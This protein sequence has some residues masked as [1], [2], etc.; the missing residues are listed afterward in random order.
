MATIAYANF[1]HQAVAP[2]VQ[3]GQNEWL[4]ELFHGPTFAFKD[5][6]MQL[7]AQL[8]NN[9]L[10][11]K[12]TKALVLGA[13]SGDTGAAALQAFSHCD[14]IHVVI[15]HPQGGVSEIQ[16]RQMTTVVAS[17]VTN[18][19][20]AGNFDDCQR[21]VKATFAEPIC[22]TPKWCLVAVNSINWAR[23][24]AQTVYYFYAAFALGAPHRKV[25]FC[26]PSGNFGN[27]YAGLLARSMGLPIEQFII[28]TNINCV[29]DDF[30]NHG[31]YTG[32]KQVHKSLAP[33]MDIAL[34]SN[35]ERFLWQLWQQDAIKVNKAMQGLQQTKVEVNLAELARDYSYIS[36]TMV[37]DTSICQRIESVFSATGYVA[38]PHTAV[39][40]EAVTRLRNSSNT[41]IISLATAHPAKFPALA[42]QLPSVPWPQLPSL[43]KLIQKEEKCINIAK[44]VSA[45]NEVLS[46]IQKI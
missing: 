3:L 20:V 12:G 35:F 21:L 23:I 32:A 2:L 11:R 18:I 24:I 31:Y 27:A 15:L 17:N 41:P 44:D 38:D 8:V 19:A 5:F 45:L 30:F 10:Q 29:L 7:L 36:S 37:D 22:I 28:A 14:N 46:A 42:E 16:R 43:Q 26:V 39:A 4:L 6:A 1:T 40:L 9:E 25:S 34:A 13:T 33:A